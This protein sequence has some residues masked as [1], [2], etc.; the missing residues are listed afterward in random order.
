MHPPVSRFLLLALASST[1]S[2]VAAAPS[3]SKRIRAAR[4]DAPP[5]LTDALAGKC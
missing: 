5:K 3:A 1:C 2:Y 4:R